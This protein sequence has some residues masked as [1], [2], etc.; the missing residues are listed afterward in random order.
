MLMLDCLFVIKSKLKIFL[1]LFSK[2]TLTSKATLIWIT[3]FLVLA[4]IWKSTFKLFIINSYLANFFLRRFTRNL[5]VLVLG[6]FDFFQ[7]WTIEKHE[8]CLVVRVS[9]LLLK[10]LQLFLMK[11]CAC[12][13]FLKWNHLLWLRA[14]EWRLSRRITLVF[15]I[16]VLFFLLRLCAQVCLC[17]QYIIYGCVEWFDLVVTTV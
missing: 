2:K 3:F 5:K 9:F 15:N 16:L 1:K 11:L 6:D 14:Y 4:F 7:I 17:V 8:K 12:F 10:M 13:F